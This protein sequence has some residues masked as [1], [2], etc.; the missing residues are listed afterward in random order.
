MFLVS[1]AALRRQG[2]MGMNERNIGYIGN[3][4]RRFYPLVDNKLETKRAARERGIPVPE[5]YGVVDYQHEVKHVT[6]GCRRL[7]VL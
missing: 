6:T 1:P 2:I 7:R 4:S 3:I 5:L